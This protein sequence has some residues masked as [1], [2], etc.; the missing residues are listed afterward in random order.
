MNYTLGAAAATFTI[1][2]LIFLGILVF[3]VAFVSFPIFDLDYFKAG[4]LYGDQLLQGT[5][6]NTLKLKPG[7]NRGQHP[8]KNRNKT[9]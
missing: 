5:L 2:F 8:L 9:V 4:L 7:Y 3:G 1:A 6:N